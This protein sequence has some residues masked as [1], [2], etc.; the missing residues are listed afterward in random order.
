[1]A[2]GGVVVGFLAAA[3]PQYRTALWITCIAVIAI[4]FDI[5]VVAS[6]TGALRNSL[7]GLI[8]VAAVIGSSFFYFGSRST[9]P[10][11]LPVSPTP[12]SGSSITSGSSTSQRANPQLSS[13]SLHRRTTRQSACP[14]EHDWQAP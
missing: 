12:G 1:M 14:G 2:L 4:A 9:R 13:R 5:A 6:L 3:S 7:A 10:L 8:A 11:T